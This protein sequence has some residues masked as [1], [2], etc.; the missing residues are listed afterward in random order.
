MTISQGSK[1]ITVLKLSSNIIVSVQDGVLLVN[2]YKLVLDFYLP[3][4]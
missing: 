3:A 1:H 2:Y 4:P